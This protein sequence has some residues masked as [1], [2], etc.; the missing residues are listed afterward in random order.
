MVQ[1]LD[2]ISVNLW[3]ILISLA[4]LTILFFLVKK[5]L[6]KPLKRMLDQRRSEIDKQYADAKDALDDAEK[7]QGEWQA[8]LDTADSEAQ[9]IIKDAT[10]KA[11]RRGDAIVEDARGRA[12]EIVR[13][14]RAEAEL[15]RK[16]A[17]D[18]IKKEIV[19]VSTALTEKVLEREVSESDHRRLI[20]SFIDEIGD[21]DDGNE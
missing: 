11:H 6:Y 14:A 1:T 17:Q 16:K 20:D 5:F 18:D 8:R 21:S 19:T 2:V 13:Q 12:D 15:E 7:S 9:R 10:D 4:N 3:Q